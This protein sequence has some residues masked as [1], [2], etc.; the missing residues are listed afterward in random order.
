M[1]PQI[2]EYQGNSQL[3]E[4]PID[5]NGQGAMM[6]ERQHHLPIIGRV[7]SKMTQGHVHIVKKKSTLYRSRRMVE[8]L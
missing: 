2:K 3:M 7:K 5:L 8:E 4:K 6:S 1:H